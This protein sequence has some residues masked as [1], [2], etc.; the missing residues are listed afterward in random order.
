MLRPDVADW[1]SLRLSLNDFIQDPSLANVDWVLLDALGAALPVLPAL[2]TIKHGSDL[3][4]SATKALESKAVF[5]GT[6]GAGIVPISK[7]MKARIADNGKGIVFQR[8]G[9]PKKGPLKNRDM[10][11]IMNPT[12]DAPNGRIIYYGPKGNPLDRYGVGGKPRSKWHHEIGEEG[13]MPGYKEW[14]NRLN[15]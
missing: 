15:D 7:G 3:I 9:A 8:P 12:P 1:A 11:R 2:G 14:F 10:V 13:P 4:Q 5:V 6:K